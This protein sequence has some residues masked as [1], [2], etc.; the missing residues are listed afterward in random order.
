[1]IGVVWHVVSV[2]LTFHCVC[3]AWCF[4]RLTVLSDSL[5]CV[6]KWVVFDPERMLS[7]TLLDPSLGVL[8]AGYAGVSLLVAGVDRWVKDE[9]F[10]LGCR[11]GLRGALLGLAWLLAPGGTAPP[12]IYFQF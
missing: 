2:V 1:V 5:I 6:Q 4:F 11:W 7:P 3:L 10:V 12:F 9:G 8:M